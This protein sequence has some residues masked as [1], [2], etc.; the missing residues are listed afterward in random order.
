MVGWQHR[1]NEHEFEKTPRDS[2]GQGRLA[3]YSP[4]DFEELDMTQRVKPPPP[5]PLRHVNEPGLLV[6]CMEPCWNTSSRG[7]GAV[8]VVTTG[9]SA[10]GS[11]LGTQWVLY[12][13]CLCMS[14][15]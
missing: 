6:P 4:W 9:S 12:R 7:R 2:E 1:L 11:G 5:P 13:H 10:C 15:L 3:G 14:F 8:P